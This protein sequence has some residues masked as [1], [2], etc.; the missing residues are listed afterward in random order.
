MITIIIMTKSISHLIII[1]V[2]IYNGKYT[3]ALDK[4][5]N[6]L[7]G[8]IILSSFIR[9]VISYSKSLMV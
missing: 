7:L 3:T 2:I 8:N 6:N 4:V 9:E 1:I 5:K